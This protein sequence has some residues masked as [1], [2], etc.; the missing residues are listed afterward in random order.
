MYLNEDNW[1]DL[2][3][4]N[5]FSN[6]RLNGSLHNAGLTSKFQPVGSYRWVFTVL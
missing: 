3:N 4:K 1:D 5:L 2:T 6:V